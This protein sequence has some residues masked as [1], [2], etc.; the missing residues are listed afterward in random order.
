MDT[1]KNNNFF[2]LE[3]QNLINSPNFYEN[4]INIQENIN[5]K[6]INKTQI[7]KKNSFLEKPIIPNRT[8][9]YFFLKDYLSDAALKFEQNE[10]PFHKIILSSASDFF[11][12]YFKTLK[13]PY[14]KT[15]VNLP[16]YI[17]SSLSEEINK[18]E[19]IENI[20]KYCYHN[21]D[22]KS[23]EESI[24]KNNFFNYLEM[25]H[26][27]QIKSLNENLEKIIIKNFLNE[28]NVVKLCE[29][30]LLFEM[31]EVHKQCKE[32]IIKNLGNI[33]NAKKEMTIL[34][35]ETFK[36]IISS[37][38]I[39]VESEKDICDLVIE[40]IKFRREIPEEI[41]ETNNDINQN[42]ENLNP[43]EYK[44]NE[45]QNEEKKENDENKEQNQEN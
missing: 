37:D 11:F 33:K 19:I 42:I 25:S 16:E 12:E 14:E 36:D 4:N 3:N 20:F 22:I 38:Q 1:I 24:T 17:K 2:S 21:Q 39:D 8:I 23:I 10:I 6:N 32:N 35:Y 30:S 43:E 28:D 7:E 34:K 9:P 44:E 41:K 15:E 5:N 31:E 13:N 26:C 29:E 45:E 40:Y 27:L 18:K